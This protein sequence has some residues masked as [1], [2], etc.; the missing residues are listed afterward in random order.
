MHQRRM[1]HAFVFGSLWFGLWAAFLLLGCSTSDS[2]RCRLHSEC[3]SG[4]CRSDGTCAPFEDGDA[5]NTADQTG[6]VDGDAASGDGQT[7]EPDLDV[8]HDETHAD[9][10]DALADQSD[11]VAD[12]V[13]DPVDEETTI[14]V[15]DTQTECSPNHDGTI[16][17]SEIPLGIGLHATYRAAQNV[18]VDMEGTAGADG[19]RT[20]DLIGPYT[21]DHTL[22]IETM[23]LTGWWFEDE[24]PDASYIVRLRD[25]EELFGVYELTET[26]L[27]LLGVASFESGL[28]ETVFSYDP[29]VV[30]MQFP[31]ELGATWQSD[32]TATGFT[33]GMPNVW[34]EEYDYTV[35]SHGELTTPF[36]T[37]SVLRIRIERTQTVGFLTTTTR[38]FLFISECF[39]PVAFVDSQDNESEVEFSSAREVMRLAP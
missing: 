9:T 19:A 36:G 39:G 34:S 31:I 37:F 23:P 28:T 1:K 4:I 7:S 25:R 2:T 21:Q 20:W 33:L 3:A 12:S 38:T 16:T 30:A 6:Q 26:Q 32:T 17:A 18:S 15:P 10:S 13:S 29:P 24:F 8:V 27:L 35:D 5:G 14:E 11:A 22:L